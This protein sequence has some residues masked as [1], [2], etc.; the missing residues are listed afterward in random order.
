MGR[1]KK[2]LRMLTHA[3]RAQFG[4]VH[5]ELC[6]DA[7][8]DDAKRPSE[9][10]AL[11]WLVRLALSSRRAAAARTRAEEEKRAAE[12]READAKAKAAA[13][14][15]AAR[16]AVVKAAE[17]WYGPR[18]NDLAT[19]VMEA[20]GAAQKARLDARAAPRR[21][22]GEEWRARRE[23]AEARAEVL[24]READALA[25]DLSRLREQFEEACRPKE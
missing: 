2:I 15:R 19:R 23:E 11:A 4:E 10:Q 5:A 12:Q 14:A 6:K 13:V 3:E 22:S 21:M 1:T 8:A 24:Q 16:D 25:S 20:R 7:E 9:T 17:A 18:L